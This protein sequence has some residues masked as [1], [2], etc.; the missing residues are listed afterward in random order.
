[1]SQKSGTKV[2][3]KMLEAIVQHNVMVEYLMYM[4]EDQMRVFEYLKISGII[5]YLVSLQTLD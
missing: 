4:F 3:A 2:K 1:M 5:I